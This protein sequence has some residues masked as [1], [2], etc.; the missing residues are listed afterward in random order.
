MKDRIA[1]AKWAW[2]EGQRAKSKE[3]R[4]KSKEKRKQIPRCA[5]DDGGGWTR[6][7]VR[8]SRCGV[9]WGGEET[10][11]REA[12]RAVWRR[13]LGVSRVRQRGGRVLCTFHRRSTGTGHIAKTQSQEC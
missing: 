5:R 1:V 11:V 12:D 4:A 2:G 9:E 7:A 10:G 6:G 13:G 8:T 3:Q